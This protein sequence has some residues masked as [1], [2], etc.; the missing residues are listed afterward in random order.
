MAT[1]PTILAGQRATAALLTSMQPLL[2]VKTVD[3]TVNNSAVLQNDNELLLPVLA[4]ATYLLDMYLIYSTGDTPDFQIQ[5]SVPSGATKSW[6]PRGLGVLVTTFYGDQ[7]STAARTLPLSLGGGGGGGLELSANVQGIVRVGSTAGNVQLQW[8][9]NS[10][11]ASDTKV[12]AD[13]WMRLTR[14]A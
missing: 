7:Q 8:A 9:Q 3:E 4:N 12:Y 11:N 14:Y 2:V 6:T 5:I 13:S 1:Y 10:A